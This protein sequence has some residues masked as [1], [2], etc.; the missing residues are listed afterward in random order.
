MIAIAYFEQ[1]LSGRHI[2]C[3][4]N[5][6]RYFRLEYP[7]VVRVPQ[8]DVIAVVCRILALTPKQLVGIRFRFSIITVTNKPGGYFLNSFLLFYLQMVRP[9][10]QKI[11]LSSQMS[12]LH[13]DAL[14]VLQALTK[15]FL[16]LVFLPI[17]LYTVYSLLKETIDNF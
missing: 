17:F 7:S 2:A 11:V 12:A 10:K 15:W 14:D 1:Q 4:Q 13:S 8:K 3:F 6:I 5:Y 9:T 16:A